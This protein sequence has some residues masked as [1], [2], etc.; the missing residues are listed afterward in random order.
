MLILG[1]S[2]TRESQEA[3]TGYLQEDGWTPTFRCWGSKRLD[4]GL[5]QIKRAKKLKQ[6]PEH[7]IVALGTNDISWV[8]P[9][10]TERRVNTLLDRLGPER[11]V[12]WVDLD[13]AYSPFSI[14]RA[15]WFNGMIR[16]VAKDRPNLKVIPWERFARKEKAA[17]FDG[18]HY[19]SSGYRLRARF[20]TDELSKRARQVDANDA[21]GPSPTASPAPTP[22]PAA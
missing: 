8:D 11:Q 1:D 15:D 20:L 4:W 16:T 10:T 2:L 17:R 9:A 22:A 7:V 13:I 12:L 14:A 21:P 5:D 6:L 18:I 19:G 3:M